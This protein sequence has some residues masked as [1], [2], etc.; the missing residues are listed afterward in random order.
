MN[1]YERT[2]QAKQWNIN[3]DGLRTHVHA[4]LHGWTYAQTN[5]LVHTSWNRPSRFMLFGYHL[6]LCFEMVC[7]L[8]V[9]CAIS[10]Q[11]RCAKLPKNDACVFPA[12]SIYIDTILRDNSDVWCSCDLCALFLCEVG[13]WVDYW[14]K[15][16]AL[17]THPTVQNRA[18]VRCNTLMTHSIRGH[19]QHR[20]NTHA[21]YSGRW[22]SVKVKSFMLIRLSNT[23][24]DQF[25]N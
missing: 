6:F 23:S 7:S 12:Y 22:G 24:S 20:S 19:W 1:E 3:R 21:E 13:F 18:S 8:T 4:Y 10:L 9:T 17:H 15:N 25:V 11:L 5:A 2:L 14:E 16:S